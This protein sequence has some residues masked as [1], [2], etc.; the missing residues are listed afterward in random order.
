MRSAIIGVCLGEQPALMRDIVLASTRLT[1]NDPRAEHGAL[2]VALAA[3]M[4]AR[5][6]ATPACKIFP[7]AFDALVGPSGRELSDLI[8]QA[9][10][11]VDS[12][13]TTEQFA[14]KIGCESGVSG[15]V[16]HTAPVALHAWFRHEDDFAGA[17]EAVVRCGGDT[18]TVAA[19]VGGIV[20]SGVGPNG[21]PPAWLDR[22][23]EW[24]RS[25]H[26]IADLGKRLDR[27]FASGA[28]QQP[29]GLNV[30]ALL[31][32]NLVFMLVVLLHGFRRLLPPY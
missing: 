5:R 7:D 8:R 20:G 15:F 25:T 1:H 27:R 13:E 22:L 16:M 4:A 9:S 6:S 10:A 12:D 14:A 24:P 23:A 26:W 30:P 18:D 21:I 28:S 32:R 17:V 11:S 31:V 19:I 3:S 2:A 29:L